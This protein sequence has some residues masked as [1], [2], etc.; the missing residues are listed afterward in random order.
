MDKKVWLIGSIGINVFILIVMLVLSWGGI[1]NSIIIFGILC[2]VG[3]FAGM[4]WIII[5]AKDAYI[6]DAEEIENGFQNGI[7]K[8]D[9][10]QMADKE[11]VWKYLREQNFF[12]ENDFLDEKYREYINNSGRYQNYRKDFSMYLSEKVLDE[13]INR[14][15]LD[16]IP[17]IMTGLG[18]LGTFLGLVIGLLQFDV[19]ETTTISYLLEGI[20][21][22][23]LTSVFGMIYSL[24]FHQYYEKSCDELYESAEAF[25]QKFHEKVFLDS[26]LEASDEILKNQKQQT[27]LLNDLTEKIAV[28]L[29]ES[30]SQSLVP[31]MND[32]KVAIEN[33]YQDLSKTQTKGVELIVDKFLGQMDEAVGNQ[34]ENLGKTIEML[35]QW[36][37]DTA[38]N[39]QEIIDGV[40]TKSKDITAMVDELERLLD[41][42]NMSILSV[43]RCNETT[44]QN[45]QKFEEMESVFQ[46]SLE[47]FKEVNVEIKDYVNIVKNAN[48]REEQYLKEIADSI[49]VKLNDSSQK[50]EVVCEKLNNTVGSVMKTSIEHTFEQFD[51]GLSDIAGHLSGTISEIQNITDKVPEVIRISFENI[52][53]QLKEYRDLIDN[54][55]HISENYC[56]KLEEESLKII[57]EEKNLSDAIG[58]MNSIIERNEIEHEE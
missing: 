43:E 53:K 31:T 22:A 26:H 14:N 16:R 19:N 2:T 37:K 41:K 3:V 30:I 9:E 17:G 20:K 28:E 52:E 36:Q 39:M 12:F 45:I 47:S 15:Y 35:C 40:M 11:Q 44:S 18:I 56:K 42:F 1:F 51:T 10:I 6:D 54:T 49:Q 4:T 32:I 48:R 5:K 29:S 33:T 8:I 27:I 13:R 58:K 50:L 38:G 57:K 25:F 23:F 7:E 46:N 21:T 55:T 34:F 24:G